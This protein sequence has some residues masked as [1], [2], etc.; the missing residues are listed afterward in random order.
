[1]AEPVSAKELPA[2]IVAEPISD[3][4]RRASSV[5]AEAL[6]TDRLARDGLLESALSRPQKEVKWLALRCLGG[7]GNFSDMVTAL[8][9]PNFRLNWPDYIDVLRAAVARD[10]ESATAVRADLEKQYPGQSEELYEMLWGYT[11][12][13]LEDGADAKLVRG[14]END[15]L[16]VR[17]VSIWNLKNIT[18]L[19]GE[20]RPEYTATKRQPL[21][22]RWWRRLEAKEIRMEPVAAK[23]PAA[24][25]PPA[26]PVPAAPTDAAPSKDS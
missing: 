19:G 12:K 8:N 5:I 11:D 24:R 10:A 2:W 13:K 22:Q 6:P 23:K 14:L 4:D 3:L 1:V 16:A 25:K 9:D 26:P 15:K 20:Y 21:T 18:G 17:V 7:V